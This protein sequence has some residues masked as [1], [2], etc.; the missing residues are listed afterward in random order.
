MV[1]EELLE[2]SVGRAVLGFWGVCSW[3]SGDN[4]CSGGLRWSNGGGR[5]LGGGVT[6]CWGFSVDGVSVEFP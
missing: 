3:L 1:F 6:F 4:G 2:A 5:W